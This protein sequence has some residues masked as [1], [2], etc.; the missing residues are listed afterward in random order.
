[1]KRIFTPFLFGLGHRSEDTETLLTNVSGQ[2]R[3]KGVRRE[4][5]WRQQT[6]LAA[7]TTA[8]AKSRMNKE[9]G[10]VM[11]EIMEAIIPF[12]A[13]AETKVNDLRAAVRKIVKL[14]VETWRYARL[15]RE[16]IEAFMPR[17][18]EI[19]E[20]PARGVWLPFSADGTSPEDSATNGTESGDMLLRV[21]P[22]VR[23]EK[24]QESFWITE[25]DHNDQGC[26]YYK[27]AALYINN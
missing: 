5:I 19:G 21:F 20:G 12:C 15:E 17:V 23:R 9:A 3:A 27:G 1:V 13:D 24:V 6:L 16:K 25:N 11:D 18:E 26:V 8:D 14:A 2:L 22:L 10:R 7:Y 4:A